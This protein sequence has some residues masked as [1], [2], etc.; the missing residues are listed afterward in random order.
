MDESQIVDVWLVFRDSIDA[1][2]IE[3]VAERYVDLCADLGTDDIVFR[4]AIGHCAELD[5]AILYYLDDDN[6]DDD[7][8]YNNEW[9]D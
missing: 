8:D 2:K 9:E 7:D 1:K 4:D 6:E 5:N 3:S